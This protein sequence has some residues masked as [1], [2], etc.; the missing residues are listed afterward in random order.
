MLLQDVIQRI[1][2]SPKLQTLKQFNMKSTHRIPLRIQMSSKR[3]HVNKEE[4]VDNLDH[5]TDD[6]KIY[7]G[8]L[9]TND[10]S[11]G[12]AGSSDPIVP[13]GVRMQQDDSNQNLQPSA[14]TFNQTRIGTKRWSSR[15]NLGHRL[16]NFKN[17]RRKQYKKKGRPIFELK[18][19]SL[20]LLNMFKRNQPLIGVQTTRRKS[21]YSGIKSLASRVTVSKVGDEKPS[22]GR[23]SPPATVDS[24]FTPYFKGST[25]F[26]ERAYLANITTPIPMENTTNNYILKK[27]NKKV[28]KKTSVFQEEQMYGGK[29][30]EST[31]Y[32]PMSTTMKKP[33]GLIRKQ[34]GG[35]PSDSLIGDRNFETFGGHQDFVPENIIKLR[36]SNFRGKTKLK[37]VEF[38]PPV[39][40]KVQS[41][42]D[43]SFNSEIS[44]FSL[45]AHKPAGIAKLE[46]SG[47]AHRRVMDDRSFDIWD[48]EKTRNYRTE[49]PKDTT[50]EINL[51]FDLK[52]QTFPAE[53][54]KFRLDKLN[55]GN[56][57]KK[58]SEVPNTKKILLLNKIN[59]SQYKQ[60][61]QDTFISRIDKFS[62]YTDSEVSNFEKEKVQPKGTSLFKRARK[63]QNYNRNNY[64]NNLLNNNEKNHDERNYQKKYLHNSNKKGANYYESDYQN[65]YLNSH[66]K[67]YRNNNQKNNANS[68]VNSYH[69][70]AV[71]I[72][73]IRMLMI[74]KQ[75]I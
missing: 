6:Q 39:Q 71:L 56:T 27:K 5:K 36:S 19:L 63:E 7:P 66:D 61:E 68:Y 30:E 4:G 9:E 32:K 50:Q 52:S 72:M 57:M 31:K 74:I 44:P 17:T 65:N 59:Q 23:F 25:P 12:H 42:L 70:D 21:S 29:V 55:R 2:S 16:N 58:I 69:K 28:V 15:T 37:T 24:G 62:F 1:K 40:R 64:K 35:G 18:P 13:Q 33:Y 3:I 60:K 46:A 75:R 10:I 48:R 8:K 11:T 47:K 41:N 22:V 20:N 73:K 45:F 67:S 53:F 43:F 54:S 26:N 51:P 34:P 38:V 49:E 14:A